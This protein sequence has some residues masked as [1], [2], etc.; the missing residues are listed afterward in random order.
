VVTNPHNREYALQWNYS[1]RFKGQN[2][3]K[4]EEVYR[5]I[6][7]S[8]TT[9]TSNILVHDERDLCAMRALLQLMNLFDSVD[10]EV[11]PCWN[12]TCCSASERCS[13]FTVERA[14]NVYDAVTNAMTVLVDDAGESPHG[15]GR[16]PQPPIQRV[17]KSLLNDL[18]WAYCFV[19]QQWLLVRLWVSCLTH[20]LLDDSSEFPFLRPSFSMTIAECVLEE[21]QQ[22]GQAV[23]EV[24]GVGMIERLHDIAMGLVMA[25][26]IYVHRRTDVSTDRIDFIL[27]RYFELLGRLRNGESRFMSALQK[28]YALVQ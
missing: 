15:I 12:K 18:Q 7:A 16:S 8:S 26:K 9:G 17:H 5:Q 6:E 13:K 14:R 22:L 20:D 3:V 25:A 1:I 2:M 4:M 23:L 19:L 24:H 10:E 28:A 11:I 27:G 21:C